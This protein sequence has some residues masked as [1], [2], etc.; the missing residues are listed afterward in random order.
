MLEV[1]PGAESR[2]PVLYQR[3]IAVSSITGLLLGN[4]TPGKDT[5]VVVVVDDDESVRESLEALIQTVG[6]RALAF[7]SAEEFLDSGQQGRTACLITDIRMPGMSGLEL[8]TRLNE[9][10]FKIPIIFITAH[11]EEKVRMQALRAG[12]VE[13][14]IKPFDDEALLDSVRAALSS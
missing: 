13:F 10:R 3:I 14:L 11:G 12:A 2:T 4:M 6:L 7:S 9:D 5:K 8:Q 1:G